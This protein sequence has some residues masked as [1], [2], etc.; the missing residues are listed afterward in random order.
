MAKAK[1]KGNKSVFEDRPSLGF[2]EAR[3]MGAVYKKDEKGEPSTVKDV[4]LDLMEAS[5]SIRESLAYT[6]IMTVMSRLAR[7]GVLIQD[8]NPKQY[9]Y[10]PVMPKFALRN[11]IVKSLDDDLG[12]G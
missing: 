5:D 6:T 1:E 3:I 2:L 9:F 4:Y 12:I 7:K 10:S 8:R 11:A